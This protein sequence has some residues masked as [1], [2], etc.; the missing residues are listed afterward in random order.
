MK[1]TSPKTFLVCHGAW[2]AGWAWKKM[3]PPMQAAGHRLVTP[4]YTGLGER[5]H[6]AH[7][8]LD[9]ESHIED[10]L[11]VI[12]YDDL[13][14]IVLVGH[15]YGGMVATGVADRARAK[16]AQMIYIDAFVPGDGQSLFDL[17][18]SGR[19]PLQKTAKDGDG[20]RVPPMQTPP[21]TSPADVEW[22][23]ARRVHM[24]IKC[25]DTKLK[26]QRGPLTLPR[27]YIYATRITPADTFGPFARMTK[28]DPA[29]RYF[30]IDASHSP[31]VTAPEALM[32][33][34]EQIA[35]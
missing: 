2:S 21:D 34:L 29:W 1:S 8:G 24:P 12:Q 26:L 22:L 14:D 23:A 18:E 28:N 5:A 25:F 15:S 16:V 30:E 10:M 27:S 9:L 19:T 31:N 32:A 35:A 20:W 7:P 17:N 11:N 13:R 3:H 6:L 4:S 33:L